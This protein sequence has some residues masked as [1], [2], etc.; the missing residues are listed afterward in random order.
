MK[1]KNKD[2]ENFYSKVYER[3]EKNHYS[4]LKLK[5][6][7]QEDADEAFKVIEWK[8]KK[9]L[10]VGC[11]TGRFANMIAKSGAHVLAI[12]FSESAIKLAKQNYQ[13]PNLYFQKMNVSKISEKYDVIVSLGTLEHMDD[14]F[15][16]LKKFKNH[17]NSKG[18][19][20][21]TNPNWTN[22]RGFIL[23]TLYYLFNAPITLAD[24]HFLTPVDHLKWAKKL[25]MKLIWKTI[26]HSWGH[27]SLL[28]DDFKRRL[29]KVLADA[30]L[31][32]KQKNIDDFLSRLE[33]NILTMNYYLPQSG[34][35]GLYVYKK[36]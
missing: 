4:T 30:N 27:G 1:I 7:P 9:V 8:N 34:A 21:I 33:K 19:I 36:V 10:E 15:K 17:L 3:N 25:N 29:P 24:N 6:R 31:P 12:D 32:I 18:K 35:V 11:G 5:N 2:L 16:I 13:H 14:P 23:L 22:P 20:I 28:I 26:E